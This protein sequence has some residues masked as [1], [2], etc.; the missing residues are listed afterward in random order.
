MRSPQKTIPSLAVTAFSLT[1]LGLWGCTRPP[2]PIQSPVHKPPTEAPVDL[3]APAMPPPPVQAEPPR[4][5]ILTA[6]VPEDCGLTAEL[7]PLGY[8]VQCMWSGG[9]CS[10]ASRLPNLASFSAI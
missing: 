6:G 10:L 2:T 9:R 1:L 8:Q 7:L 3:A 4:E 5:G